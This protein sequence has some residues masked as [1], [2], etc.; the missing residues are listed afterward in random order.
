MNDKPTVFIA[1]SSE[2]K[3]VAEAVLVKLEEEFR[4]KLWTNAFDLSSVTITTLVS[5]T[6]EVDYSVFVFYPDDKTIIREKEYNTVRDNVLLELGM[7]IGTLGL[8][9]CFILAP[10]S[11][12]STFRLPIDLAGVTASFYNDKEEQYID[13]V[14]GSCAKIKQSIKKLELQKIKT[15]S[16]NEVDMLKQQISSMQSKVWGLNNDIQRANEQTQLFFESIK[17]F[18]FSVAK[19]ATPAE[20]KAWETGAKE[21]YLKEVKIREHDVY[22]IDKDII[23]PS[24]HGANALSIIIEKGIRVYGINKWSHNSIYYMDGFRTDTRV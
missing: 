14:T 6:K 13:A 12:E 17:N 2:A 1:S 21:T 10:K 16:T 20:I 7:F 9:K 18:F 23:I 19:H 11:T 15:K 8:E 5:K 4:V 24:F 3:D 22:Y